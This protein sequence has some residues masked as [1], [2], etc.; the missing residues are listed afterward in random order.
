M[1]VQELPWSDRFD[2]AIL[3]D[4]MHH[5]DDEAAT[6]E[7]ILKTLVP[8]RPDLHPRGRS[9]RARLGRRAAADRGDGGVRDARVAVRPRLPGGGRRAGGLHRCAAVRRGRRAGRGRRRRGHVQSHARAL[10][11]PRRQAGA[12]DEHPDRDEAARRRRRSRV[13]CGDHRRRLVAP[14]RARA[15]ARARGAD[16]QHGRHVLADGT[17]RARRGHDR[18]VRAAPGRVAARAPARLRCRGRS[19]PARSSP[20][21]SPSR[22]TRPGMP[23][24]SRSTASARGSRGSRTWARARS[25]RRSRADRGAMR[26]VFDVTPLSQPRTGIGNYLLGMLARASTPSSSCA[27]TTGAATARRRA[28][29]ATRAGTGSRSREPRSATAS[30]CCTARR[31]A[32]RSARGAARRDDPRRGR[33]PASRAF[34]RWTRTYSA[35][36]LPRVARAADRDRRRLRVHAR[37]AGRAPRRAGEQDPRHPVRRRPAVH[38]R[39]GPPPTATTSSPS[40][41][42][43]RGRTSPGCSRASGAPASTGSSSAS[44]GPRAGATSSVDGDRVRRLTGRRR[45]GARAALPRR[46]GGRLRLALRGL[47][48]ARARGDGLRAAGRRARGPPVQRVRA[49]RR[50]RGR[51][52]RPR[53]DRRRPAAGRSPRDRRPSARSGRPTSRWERAVQAHVDLYRELAG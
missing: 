30:R 32:R 50:V 41:R 13:L 18:P 52:A 29:C 10:L 38:G 33:A 34:N 24:R 26:I 9:A 35:K 49:R 3:Y 6:L 40:R 47:R 27:A 1:P 28:S 39:T 53:L 36:S 25:S 8:G 44:S 45:R 14:G 2:A 16:P 46:G 17:V 22:G 4:T 42:S 51:S 12:R 20:S 23:T 43:S 5:F 31:C 11:V 48:P 19:R 21:S 7:V 37:R 15:P